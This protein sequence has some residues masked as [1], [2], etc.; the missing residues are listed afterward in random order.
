MR[1]YRK[2]RNRQFFLIVSDDREIIRVPLTPLGNQFQMGNCRKLL[3]CE[4]LT[5][6]DKKLSLTADKAI[7]KLHQV[8][9][10][11]SGAGICE[12]K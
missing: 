8:L 11:W 7:H 3:G 6:I 1:I 2:Q 10:E 5:P 9:I 12:I 4:C